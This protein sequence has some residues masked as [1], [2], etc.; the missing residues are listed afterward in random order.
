MLLKPLGGR[1]RGAGPFRRQASRVSEKSFETMANAAPVMIW[2]SGLD[3]GCTFFNQ[4]WLDFT[5]RTMEEQLGNGWAENVHAEDLA[6]CMDIYLKAF[7]ARVRF[8]MEYRLRRVDGEYRWVFDTGTPLFSPNGVFLGFIGSC[9][10]ITERKLAEEALRESEDRYKDLVENSGILFGTHDLQGVMLSANRAAARFSGVERAEDLVGLR[11]RDFLAPDV[12]GLFDDYLARVRKEGHTQGLMKVR[13]RSGDE[14]FLEYYNSLRSEDLKNPIVR[15]IG[16]DITEQ[17]RAERAVCDAEERYRLVAENSRDLIKLLDPQGNILYSSPSHLAVLGY[18]PKDLVG[19]SVLKIIHP[20]DHSLACAGLEEVRQSRGTK[21]LELRIV[22]KGGGMLEVEAILSAIL[23]EK[24]SVHHILLAARDITQRKRAEHVSRSQTAALTRTL[25]SLAA[26]PGL[27]LDTFLGHVL[28]A[29]SEQLD[30][31]SCALYVQDAEGSSPPRYM[32]YESGRVLEGGNEESFAASSPKLAREKSPVCLLMSQTRS[33]QV[34]ANAPDNGL[35]PAEIRAWAAA[36]QVKTILIVPLLS[37]DK[38]IGVLT[39]R[40][41]EDRTYHA[42]EMELAQAL[43]HQATLAVHLAR[44]AEREQQSVLLKERNRMAQE[45]HDTLAQ[46]LTGI[47]VQLEAAADAAGEDGD[48]ARRR[49]DLAQRLARESLAEARRSVWALQPRLLENSDLATALRTFLEQF[50]QNGTVQ[51][52]LVVWGT[53]RQ[54]PPETESNL[55]RI[56]QEALANSMNHARATSVRVTLVFEARRV[57]LLVEDDGVGFDP[58]AEKSPAGFGLRSMR[59]RARRIGGR[60]RIHSRPGRGTR[61]QVTAP[62]AV[63]RPL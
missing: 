33:P 7:R 11:V 43:A 2:M 59:E 16:R 19:G 26:D 6:A 12:Q 15:C 63:K 42:E 35:L 58:S 21:T 24:G 36:H 30:G 62:V 29:I 45:I 14:R 22:A 31:A 13:T 23:D 9:V 27:D 44:L 49:I 55:L 8:E 50:A 47:V 52:K 3:A 17:R 10:D 60:V 18:A 38:L 28:R 5:G 41:G 51:A 37:G 53:A 56:G 20:D 4:V 39:V 54:L 46:G 34:I 1:R 25:N 61:I 32:V 57:Q 40:S 48:E